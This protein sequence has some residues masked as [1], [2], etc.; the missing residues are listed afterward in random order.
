[1][2]NMERQRVI[3]ILIITAIVGILAIF[4]LYP[5]F[6]D[7]NRFAGDYTSN[8][9]SESILFLRNLDANRSYSAR[10]SMNNTTW[11]DPETNFQ[12]I[13][14]SSFNRLKIPESVRPGNYSVRIIIDGNNSGEYPV[15]IPSDSLFV[16]YP[17]GQIERKPW[18]FIE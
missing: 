13:P 8:P 3:F 16:L 7:D 1:M 10:V 15:T 12:P 2:D 14:P 11:L 6:P 5:G 18:V 9:L 4:S 17:G